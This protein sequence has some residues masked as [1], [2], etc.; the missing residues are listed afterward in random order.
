[1]KILLR[2]SMNEDNIIMS[3]EEQLHGMIEKIIKILS[4]LE[5]MSPTFGAENTALSLINCRNLIDDII[6]SIAFTNA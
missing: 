2:E 6:N 3:Y 5:K 1:M 4:D